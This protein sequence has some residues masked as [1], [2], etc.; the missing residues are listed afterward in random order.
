MVEDDDDLSTG[1]YNRRP[2]FFGAIEE[3]NKHKILN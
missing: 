1:I 2:I 3:M